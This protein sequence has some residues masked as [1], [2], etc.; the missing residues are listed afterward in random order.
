MVADRL[1]PVDGLRGFAVVLMMLHHFPNWLLSGKDDSML[2]AFFVLVSRLA[3]PLFL[4]IV[5]VSL[6]L[7]VERRKQTQ[8][9]S[10]ILKHLLLR[11]ALLFAG[12]YLMNAIVYYDIMEFNILHTIGASIILLAYPAVKSTPKAQAAAFLLIAAASVAAPPSLG[13]PE[14]VDLVQ[15]PPLPWTLYSAVGL[16]AGSLFIRL[17]AKGKSEQIPYAMESA[18]VISLAAAAAAVA[19]GSGISIVP[20]TWTYLALLMTAVA[21]VTAIFFVVYGLQYTAAFTK[22]LE[23]YGVYAIEVYFIHLL[24]AATIPGLLGLLDKLTEAETV[25]Y[26]LLFFAVSCPILMHYAERRFT[27]EPK[28]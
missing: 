8:K 27:E 19:L 20:P 25:A 14:F 2:Y 4:F 22:P 12:G 17:R 23:A 9:D 26:M 7:S 10:E 15:Y 28:K 24:F 5:G 3:A 11:G 16:I 13:S 6:T 18:A 1:R 21:Y